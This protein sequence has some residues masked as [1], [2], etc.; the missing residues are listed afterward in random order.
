MI[1]NL[2]PTKEVNTVDPSHYQF[3]AE[4]YYQ[5]SRV[6]DT[7]S[8]HHPPQSEARKDICEKMKVDL[9]E[10]EDRKNGTK[11][12]KTV[13]LVMSCFAMQFEVEQMNEFNM[14]VSR[15]CGVL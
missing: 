14:K 10:W 7:Q 8:L 9:E 12:S 2:A 13:P 5:R 6:D 15:D 11:E 4:D 1:S 3:D